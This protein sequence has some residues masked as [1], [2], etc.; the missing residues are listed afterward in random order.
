MNINTLNK[1]G[2]PVVEGKNWQEN[3]WSWQ[4]IQLDLETRGFGSNYIFDCSV[5][6]DMKNSSRK[7]IYVNIRRQQK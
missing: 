3:V 4:K 1:I 7:V 5:E 6:V 2:W